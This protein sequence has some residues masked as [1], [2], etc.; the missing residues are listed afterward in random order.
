MSDYPAKLPDQE[1]KFGKDNGV[2][3]NEVEAA[4][5]WEYLRENN[6]LRTKPGPT[7]DR[8][9]QLA[10]FYRW[11]V[12]EYFTHGASA[13][14]F[15]KKKAWRELNDDLRKTLGTNLPGGRIP[16]FVIDPTSISKGMY[17]GNLGFKELQVFVDWSFTDRQIAQ[18]FERDL[19]GIRPRDGWAP[20]RRARKAK[21]TSREP[22]VIHPLCPDPRAALGWLGSLRRLK[23]WKRNLEEMAEAY[24]FS[25]S[26]GGVE[27]WKRDAGRAKRVIAWMRT[28]NPTYL[29]TLPKAKSRKQ[30]SR[31]VSDEVVMQSELDR[32]PPGKK[33][34]LFIFDGSNV[35]CGATGFTDDKAALKPFVDGLTGLT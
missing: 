22:I 16:A 9:W 31:Y 13:V 1:Y 10:V 21:G 33:A 32:I 8:E 35:T 28:G 4:F 25:K 34:I 6:N 30:R 27:N 20:V 7:N 15:K 17:M 11:H 19:A 26:Y 18:G 23:G 29:E 3:D 12:A 2:S 14:A 24:G 5:W